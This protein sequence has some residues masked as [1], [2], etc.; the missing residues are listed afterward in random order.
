[1]SI[2]RQTDNTIVFHYG[3]DNEEVY[4]IISSLPVDDDIKVLIVGRDGEKGFRFVAE[5][6]EDT[7]LEQC[8]GATWVEIEAEQVGDP[9]DI[10]VRRMFVLDRNTQAELPKLTEKERSQVGMYGCTE[11]QMVEAAVSCNMKDPF[12]LNHY[13]MAI[14]SDVQE[15]MERGNIET[16]R[17][18]VNRA[19]FFVHSSCKIIRGV[20]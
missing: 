18:Y 7:R 4:N 1:M 20:S 5:N 6:L 19:K 2:Q 8:T 16:A 11:R 13:A 15:E 9:V 14:L 10:R 3:T 12:D 17:Q